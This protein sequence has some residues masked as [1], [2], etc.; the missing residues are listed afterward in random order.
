MKRTKTQK[1]TYLEESV[2]SELALS[3]GENIEDRTISDLDFSS[4]KFELESL[5]GLKIVSWKNLRRI[6][7]S[8][9][10]LDKLDKLLNKFS[11]LET[12]LAI[13]NLIT[14]VDLSLPNLVELD[15]S[16]NYLTQMP[17]LSGLP[18]LE[19]LLLSFNEIN[20]GFQEL[21]NTKNL[22]TLDLSNNRIDLSA[23]EYE[24]F[25]STLQTTPK[26]ENLRL[27]NNPFCETILE[28]EFYMIHELS[29]LKLLNNEPLSK[30]FIEEIQAKPMKSLKEVH[31]ETGEKPQKRNIQAEYSRQEMPR[32]EDLHINLQK[33]KNDPTQCLSLFKKVAQ[34]AEAIVN[35]PEERFIIFKANSSEEKSAISMNIDSFLQEAVMMIED[36]PTMR[37]PVLRIIASLCE[38][39]ESNFGHKCLLTLEDLLVS[40]PEVAS[41]IEEIIRKI[42]IPKVKVQDVDRVSKDLLK[43]LVRLCKD[44][45]ISEILKDLVDTMVIWVKREVNFEEEKLMQSEIP[46]EVKEDLHSYAMALIAFAANER[47]NAESMTTK[48]VADFTAKLL[49]IME[50]ETE[51]SNILGKQETVKSSIRRLKYVLKIM[52]NL[53]SYSSKA[54]SVFV[55]EEIHQKLLRDIWEYL[56][57]YKANGYTFGGESTEST[58]IMFYKLMTAYFN[59]LG[60]LSSDSKCIEYILFSARQILEEI[61]NIA[62][63]PRID[64]VLLTSILKLVSSI[65][66]SKILQS[67]EH[68][69]QFKYFS[70]S[71]RKMLPFMGYLGGKKYKSICALG[72]KYAKGTMI[73]QEPI[74][75]SS[76][77]NKFLHELFVSIIDL[78]RFFSEKSVEENTQSPVIQEICK[79]VSNT[80][81]S[82]NREEHLFN[83]LEIPNDSVKLAVVKCLDKIPIE[84]IDIEETG[85]IVR[86]L[87]NY[88]NLGVGRTEEVLS[89]VFLLLNKLVMDP[90]KGEDFRNKFGEMVIS[91]CLSILNRN[92]Q[93]DLRDN[94]QEN[95]EKLYLTLSCVMFLKKC[96]SFESLK[97]F[98]ENKN[99]EEKMKSILKAEELYRTENEAPVE[100]ERTLVGKR[101]ECLL[102]CLIGSNHLHPYDYVA[103]R[104]FQMMADVLMGLKETRIFESKFGSNQLEELIRFNRESW[105]IRINQERS[106]WISPEAAQEFQEEKSSGFYVQ[107]QKFCQLKAVSTLLMFLMGKSS[108]ENLDLEK[109]LQE[110]YNPKFEKSTLLRQV[111]AKTDEINDKY[112]NEKEKTEQKEKKSLS[113]Q[114]VENLETEDPNLLKK[115]ME[116][117]D[118]GSSNSYAL[119]KELVMVNVYAPQNE[120]LE[121]RAL[122]L[123]AFL[124]CCYSAIE[125]GPLNTR[126]E[127]LSQL[128][129]PTTLQNITKLCATTGWK[130]AALGAKYL[131]VVK[132]IIR[133][134]PTYNFRVQEDTILFET[135][136]LA[137]NEI[138]E[139]IEF[140]IANQERNPLS[141]EDEFLI[142]ELASVGNSISQAVNTFQWSENDETVYI[143]RTSQVIRSAQEQVA[144]YLLQELIPVS[145]IKS[146]VEM[147]FYIM[148]KN[149]R[150]DPNAYKKP[151]KEMEY[152][153]KSREQIG[154]LLGMYLAI[155]QE[156]K[157]RVIEF[158]KVGTVFESKVMN[159]TYIQEVL[160]KASF[161]LFTIELTKY[162]KEE[163]T[164]FK[165][166]QSKVTERIAGIC[167]TDMFNSSKW[168]KKLVVVTS[169]CFY[170]LNPATSPPC[171]LCGEDRFCPSPPSY[172]MHI[173]FRDISKVVT[174]PGIPQLFSIE[175][176]FKKNPKYLTFRCK[177][178]S[179]GKQLSGLLSEL[180]AE[181][182]TGDLNED[183]AEDSGS[184]SLM[185]DFCLRDSLENLL[186]RH[187]K[188]QVKKAIF[189]SYNP[190]KGFAMFSKPKVFENCYLTV[191]T[192]K[193]SLLL[194]DCNFKH[195]NFFNPATSVELTSQIVATRAIE[196]NLFK[197]YKEFDLG[198]C[199]RAK[200]PKTSDFKIILE[201]DRTKHTFVF[202]DDM[203]LEVFQRNV[204][205][206]VTKLKGGKKLQENPKNLF[207]K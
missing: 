109:T 140:K 131:R 108:M 25:I 179:G 191:L 127:V 150:M 113:L 97:P 13:N 160:N 22:L 45:D 17:D 188:G 141:K 207:D 106:T 67:D 202:Q 62:I 100:I 116:G 68:S 6:N 177:Y 8:N 123:A 96:S 200:V 80:L 73:G 90:E 63:M 23:L 26:L 37:K 112:L 64:P 43:G 186:F 145:S 32:L 15:L 19:Q 129:H 194:L 187:D 42:I 50:R 87:G 205:R 99:A 65:L 183:F 60:G 101:I 124:R 133:L 46:Q 76:L 44:R 174:F 165:L 115:A 147:L 120:K 193:N 38:V 204:M 28:Y 66:N 7:A 169:R 91:E 171:P 118:I 49:K 56:M 78:I 170:L 182:E 58:E 93:R 190:R 71:L 10:A 168:E 30:A 195:W 84:E 103:L 198:K 139:F 158:C 77:T 161:I 110:Q 181:I 135:I 18:R 173:E 9:N 11:K 126:M 132:H 24:Q 146:Y 36:M 178:Y 82:N 151:E 104:V 4:D 167:W 3:K 27:M 172:G 197:I 114:D 5:E 81:N 21:S 39:E 130:Y 14:I 34:D 72:E 137:L 148:T 98:F 185:E 48:R 180:K 33:A 83:C 166:P 40:G 157:Y 85:H 149:E 92:Q 156:S 144:A 196:P 16:R 153:D 20:S 94:E 59:A 35:K 105:S 162:M 69:E 61:L 203:T 155:C 31:K 159:P 154:D 152:L 136:S 54:A 163:S 2:L 75:I 206:E 117:E 189:C 86:I 111:L 119:S 102:N 74:V 79:Q 201:I 199:D 57:F 41:E 1:I 107:H 53:S 52:Q 121:L 142:S 138:I 12:V 176:S 88:K 51:P 55:A 122:V 128:K 184:H 125:F 89:Q 143:E 29:G 164:Q 95:K 175:Y 134:S 47:K 192:S 70:E